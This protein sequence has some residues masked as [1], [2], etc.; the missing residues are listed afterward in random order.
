MRPLLSSFTG[1]GCVRFPARLMLVL[2]LASPSFGWASRNVQPGDTAPDIKLPDA[3]GTEV[4]LADFAGKPVLVAFW[5]ERNA[6][7]KEHSWEVLAA[8]EQMGRQFTDHELEVI[9]VRFPPHDGGDLE[10]LT[11]QHGLTMPMLVAPDESIYSE[12]GLFIL[13]TVMLVD[14]EFKVLEFVGYTQKMA[15]KLQGAVELML[16]LKTAAEIEAELHPQRLAVADGTKTAA[17]HFNV[18]RRFLAKGRL[19]EAEKELEKALAADPG[20]TA[21]LFAQAELWLLQGKAEDALKVSDRGLDL[22]PDDR[23]GILIN[24]RALAATGET[25]EALEYL[26][27]FRGKDRRHA[28]ALVAVANIHRRAGDLEKAVEAFAKAVEILLREP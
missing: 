19:D 15:G 17:R 18:G 16:G 9:A 28:E 3:S 12:Y 21:A 22:E 26:S 5:A 4:A 14:R 13:P 25:E 6:V 27:E 11:K 20:F 23:G 10:S 2:L 8:C 1:P 24:A 7:M